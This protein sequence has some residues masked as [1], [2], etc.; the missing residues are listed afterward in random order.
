VDS[1]IV[2]FDGKWWMYTSSAAEGSALQLYYADDLM[3]PWNEHPSSPVVRVQGNIARPGGRVLA[4]DSRLIR[5]QQDLDPT[6]NHQL[7]AFEVTELTTTAY[8]ERRLSTDP[9]LGA[10]GSGWNEKAMHHI[11]PHEIGENR[12]IASVDGF[13][14]YLVFGLEY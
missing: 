1:S 2:R 5:Y 10:S 11:D 7:W 6:W 4:Y 8:K 13:G 14:T 12:W 9:I 3:G